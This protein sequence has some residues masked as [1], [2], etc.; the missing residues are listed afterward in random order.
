VKS[1][2]ANI[3]IDLVQ[4]HDKGLRWNMLVLPFPML[5]PGLGRVTSVP[6][7]ITQEG[8]DFRLGSSNKSRLLG[9]VRR[10]TCSAK[11]IIERLVP[12]AKSRLIFE[13]C[14]AS[15]VCS[16]DS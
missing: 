9:L 15:E 3:A 6:T 7:I 2:T 1:L 8:S 11:G 14:N 10:C 16:L 4:R 5:M 12:N 13:V